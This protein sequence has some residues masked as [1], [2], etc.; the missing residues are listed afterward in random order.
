VFALVQGRDKLCPYRFWNRSCN[1]RTLLIQRADR[2]VRPYGILK[3][4]FVEFL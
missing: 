4:G 1:Y 3:L 2:G